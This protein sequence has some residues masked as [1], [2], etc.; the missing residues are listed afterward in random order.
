MIRTTQSEK[1]IDSLG[2]LNILLYEEAPFRTT[3]FKLEDL[4]TNSLG[5]NVMMTRLGTVSFK[6]LEARAFEEWAFSSTMTNGINVLKYI[7]FF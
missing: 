7:M 3:E 6:K 2:D 1:Y 5:S 4:R